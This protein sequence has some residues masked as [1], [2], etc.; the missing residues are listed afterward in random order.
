[1]SWNCLV[2]PLD[3]KGNVDQSA[4]SASLQNLTVGQKFGL[5]CS[6]APE[7][8][9]FQKLTIV[10]GAKA[11][12]KY[13]LVLSYVE[14]LKPEGGRF[15]VVG[16]LTGTHK[17]ENLALTDGTNYVTL[18]G[19]EWAVE[20][21][22]EQGKQQQPFGPFGPFQMKYPMWFWG[23]LGILVLLVGWFVFYKFKKFFQRRKM[24][25]DL[26]RF[27]SAKSPLEELYSELRKIEKNYLGAS[28]I[29]RAFVDPLFSGFKMFLVRSFK[30]PAISWSRG[31]VIREFK[32]Y[33]R[34]VYEKVG[35][36]IIRTYVEIEKAEKKQVLSSIDAEQLLKM[37]RMTCENLWTEKVSREK[38][39]LS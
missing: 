6:G 34:V 10:A 17:G 33:H 13:K 29:D 14:D 32:K 9:D 39:G 21:V 11:P 28:K 30:I 4:P 20:S 15:V 7:N 22:L 26:D 19:F 12:D 38:R 25:K 3:A 24:L 8:L 16:Y 37:C 18:N 31:Q 1:M 23:V 5:T 27:R 35:V 36:D 2:S